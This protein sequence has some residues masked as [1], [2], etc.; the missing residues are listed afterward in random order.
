[1][2]RVRENYHSELLS[3]SDRNMNGR[4]NSEAAG[5]KTLRTVDF[6]RMAT[7]HGCGSSHY[8]LVHD[9]SQ[10]RPGGGEA[11]ALEPRDNLR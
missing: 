9:L 1:M 4:L 2:V 11:G 8:F 7:P 6:S 10:T 5:R 3:R